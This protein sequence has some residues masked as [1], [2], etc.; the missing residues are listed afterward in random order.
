[1]TLIWIG[2]IVWHLFG[3]AYALSKQG[4]LR[5][6]LRRTC[7]RRRGRTEWQKEPCSAMVTR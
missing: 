6:L 4:L 5:L 1:M 3:V 7:S 2:L